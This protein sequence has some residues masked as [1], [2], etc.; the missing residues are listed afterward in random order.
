[1]SETAQH[2]KCKGTGKFQ[3]AIKKNNWDP[4]TRRKKYDRQI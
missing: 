1:M 3:Y 2:R 4:D